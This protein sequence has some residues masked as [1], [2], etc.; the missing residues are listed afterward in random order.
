MKKHS[1]ILL[2]LAA[3][4]F[5][6]IPSSA[7]KTPG[8]LPDLLLR[9]DDIGMNHAVNTAA[10]QLAESGIPFSTSVMFACPWY[11][12]AV[13]I[14]KN[15][16]HVTV[17]VHLTLNAE[18]RNYRWGPVT[19]REAVPSLV[20]SD[21]YFL[22]SIEAFLQSNYKLEEVEKELTAQVERALSSG[23][24]ITYLDPHMGMAIAT[25]ELRAIVEKLAQKYRLAIS[26]YFGED[27]KS[28]WSVPVAVKKQEF[29]L[30]VNNLKAGKTNLVE[31]HIAHATPEMDVLVDMNSSLMNTAEGTPQASQHRKTELEM[32]L[33]PEF[34]TLIGKKFNLVTYSDLARVPG[35]S[36]MKRPI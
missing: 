7:Q 20:D 13:S 32:L 10:Q 17:G 27:Y 36:A 4:L 18:W 26:T 11:Q 12:E 16:P 24:K 30:H 25:P 29:M 19:G 1:C 35:I 34:R 8:K 21:G 6:A 14:L 15:H 22:P 2:L 28:M 33:S 9:V 3:I 31:L 23:L 5:I